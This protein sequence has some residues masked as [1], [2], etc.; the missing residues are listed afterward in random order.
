MRMK[1][2][3]AAWLIILI[4]FALHTHSLPYTVTTA[5][6]KAY[7]DFKSNKDAFT[8]IASTTYL[9]G[10]IFSSLFG[11]DRVKEIPVPE[12]LEA[13][14]IGSIFTVEEVLYFEYEAAIMWTTSFGILYAEDEPSLDE[15]YQLEPVEDNWYYYRIVS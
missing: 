14:G 10:N 4:G 15:W 13:I 5:K 6:A 12:E 2:I 1:W 8:H 11:I 9:G 7:S 3:V